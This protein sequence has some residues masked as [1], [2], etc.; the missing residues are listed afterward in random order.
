MQNELEFYQLSA[1]GDRKLNEDCMGHR[2]CSDYAVFVVADGLGGHHGGEKAS[3]F[4]CR[5]LLTLAA[6]HQ[7]QLQ[8]RGA[9]AIKAWMYAAVAKMREA[10]ADDPVIKVAHTTCAF[11]YLDRTRLLAVHCG[12]SRIY[13][14]TASEVLWRSR[15]HSV[16]QKFLDQGLIGEREMGAH[17]EQNRLTHTINAL[18]KPV[19]DIQV[20]PALQSGETFMLCTDGF[21]ENLKEQDLLLLSQP[22]SGKAELKK[23]AQTMVLR[24]KGKADNVTV[25]WLR[26]L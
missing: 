3:Q 25:Q 21:W 20:F 10:F 11:V 7:Q 26:K 12:D 19:F 14:L 24:A 4:F 15:D 13:R 18:K 1:V 23:V 6:E 17:S 9:P 5:A 2:V 8:Q 16:T 22:E